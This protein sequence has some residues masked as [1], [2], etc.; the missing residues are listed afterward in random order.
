MIAMIMLTSCDES[1]I[2][3]LP[4]LQPE[5]VEFKVTNPEAVGTI[6]K[7]NGTVLLKVP[8]YADIQS[9]VPDIHVSYGSTVTPASG[10]AVDFSSPVTFT[11]E[12]GGITKSYTVTVQ[13]GALDTKSARILVLGTADNVNSITNEDEKAATSWA[14]G[15]FDL[16]TY[17]SFSAFK[18]NTAVLEEIDAVWWHFDTSYELPAGN[19]ALPDIAF[20]E[21]IVTALRNFRNNGGGIYL[22][23]FATQYLKTLEVVPAAGN[24]D[25]QGGAPADFANADNWGI[26]FKGHKEHPIFEGLRTKVATKEGEVDEDDVAFLISGGA[27]RKDNKSW[28]VVINEDFPYGVDLAST[29]WDKDHNILVLLAEF[30]GT[31]TQ[32]KVVA[33]SAGAYDWFSVDGENTFM[34]NVEKITQNILL[35][36]ATPKGN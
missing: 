10:T 36:T 31:E 14:L 27:S 32:G 25:E 13:P 28:W 34:D 9:L 18:A 21:T 24:P 7:T 17:M 19:F 30:P 35:Y 29:E 1:G 20:D 3:D 8:I 4:Q 11:I 2:H 12:N 5:L 26:S 33:F 15:T 6:D 22:S 16:A 23:G